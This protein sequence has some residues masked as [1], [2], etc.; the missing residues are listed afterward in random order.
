MTGDNKFTLEP[1]TP[2]LVRL[3]KAGDRQAVCLTVISCNPSASLGSHH[4]ELSCPCQQKAPPHSY[5]SMQQ[6]PSYAPLKSSG[7]NTPACQSAS[8]V[9]R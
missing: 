7:L 9:L 2:L 5:D 8:A 1:A 4:G 6:I 3:F